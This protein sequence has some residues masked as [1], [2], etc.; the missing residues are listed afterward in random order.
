M[1]ALAADRQAQTT[2]YRTL[3]IAGEQFGVSPDELSAE[4]IREVRRI[5]RNEVELEQLV[6]NSAEARHVTVP[7]SQLDAALEQIRQRYD[8][9]DQFTEALALNGLDE[10]DIRAGVR[11]ELRVESVMELVASRAV[12]VDETEATLFYY[13]HQEQFRKPETR[14]VRHILITVNND[15][16]ENQ[17][18]AA[19]QRLQ[20]VYERL[21]R[22][23]ERFNEQAMKHSECPSGMNGGLLG[24]LK[25]G[26]LYPQLDDALFAMGEGD[27]RGPL[28]TEIGWHL[29]L[30]EKISPQQ[31]MPLHQVL[32]QLMEELQQRQNRRSQKLWLRQQAD[33]QR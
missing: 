14:T 2:G 16:S 3:R 8:D 29:L 19:L 9:D 6:L 21:Q 20:A 25:S 28:E 5:A 31:I 17:R 4:Q 32:P 24:E 30:C 15:Y 33:S 12:R 13:L 7:D 18:D 27:I 26:V 23:P 22:A 10:E 1:T 11:Q